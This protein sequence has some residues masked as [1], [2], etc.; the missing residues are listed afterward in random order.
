MNIRLIVIGG[1]KDGLE[2][3]VSTPQFLIGRDDNCHI[4]PESKLI[5]GLHCLIAVSDNSVLLE[6]FGGAVGTLVNG[7]R[8]RQ[9]CGLRDQDRIKIG[10]L[11]FEVR[12]VVDGAHTGTGPVRTAE[13]A[14][15]HTVSAAEGGE[16][17]IL[18]WVK[19]EE[20][21][22]P[23]PP[24]PVTFGHASRGSHLEKGNAAVTAPDRRGLMGVEWDWIDLLL[25]SAICP[26]V[27]VLL[28][29]VPTFWI[30]RGGGGLLLGGL[31]YAFIGRKNRTN[32]LEL[33][34]L[35]AAIGILAVLVLG[36]MLPTP[37]MW[38][39]A[40][41]VLL[42]AVGLTLAVRAVRTPGRR[43]DERSVALL[44]AIGLI[45][46]TA[47]VITLLLLDS[48]WLRLDGVG[49]LLM[50]LLSVRWFR[51]NRPIKESA[52][53]RMLVSAAVGILLLAVLGFLFPI[54]SWWPEWLNLR[55]WPGWGDVQHFWSWFRWQVLRNWWHLAWLRWG[56]VAFWAAMIAVSMVIRVRRESLRLDRG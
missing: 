49:I 33:D 8:V 50:M 3:P 17:E 31:G 52:D 27:I 28:S 22:I 4:R 29:L 40:A 51:R 2:I 35:N 54:V 53:K 46:F 12:L 42:G 39:S 41:A 56:M 21:A 38:Q 5:S 34:E 44:A 47:I 13:G 25:L 18:D 43:W 24:G 11:E 45:T 10:D 1:K 30:W 15:H 37:W 7:K 23:S 14:S 48:L 6:D 9:R 36:L 19:Q 55:Q 16:A 32:S 26:L 20:M